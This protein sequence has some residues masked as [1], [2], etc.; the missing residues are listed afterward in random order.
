MSTELVLF[1]NIVESVFSSSF[2]IVNK[3]NSFEC[4][5]VRHL[6]LKAEPGASAGN[7]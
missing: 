7:L 2:E 5:A 1:K 6:T 4:W 3:K